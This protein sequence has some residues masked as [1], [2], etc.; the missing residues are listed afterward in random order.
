[1][2]QNES[3]SRWKLNETGGICWEVGSDNHL[4]HED[5]IEMSGMAIS[6]IIRY[7]VNANGELQLSRLLIWPALRTIPNDTHASLTKEFSVELSLQLSICGKSIGVEKPN[8][9]TFDGVLTVYSHT[10]AGIAIVRS[11]FP[12]TDLHAYV[13]M[14][15]L[16]NQSDKMVEIEIE[17][18]N[19]TYHRRGVKGIY[20]LESICNAPATVR[21]H[22]NERTTFALIVHGRGIMED[23]PIIDWQQE[24]A[25]REGLVRRSAR[26]LRLETPDPVLNEGF[27]LAKLRLME[28]IYET[29]SGLMHSPGGGIF[30]AAVWT[31]DQ[32]EYAGPFFAF[33]NDPVGIA[34]SL[35]AYRLFMPFMGP[36]FDPIPT[37]IIAEGTDIWEG[38]GDRGDA[39]MYAYGAS[40]FALIL[41]DRAIAEEL[42]PSI[43]WCLEYNR[44][45]LTSEG[46][47]ASDSDELEN[48]FPSG[49][50]NLSTSSLGYGALRN[51]ASL[52]RSLGKTAETEAFEA[53]AKELAEAIERYFGAEV[54][55]FATYRYY[56]GNDVLRSW[57]CLPLTMG[58]MQRQEGTLEA[59]FDSRLWTPDG[60]ATQAGDTTFWDRSTL[61]GF[62]AAFN[63]GETER[64]MPYLSAYA[65]KRLLGEHVPYPVEAYPE[66][67]Q[68]H[69]S[70]EC[71]LYGRVFTEGMF[72]IKP[73]ALD[74]FEC[75]PR[76]PKAW[77]NMALRDIQLCGRLMDLIVTRE[78]EEGINI[79]V[80]HAEKEVVKFI[81][82]DEKLL[83]R[84]THDQPIIELT[85]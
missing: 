79:R 62:R 71:A 29:K 85:T 78:L 46:I 16:T 64:V 43:C 54:E 22:P 21:L 82:P 52:A 11:M 13:E 65:R 1:M 26:F 30:Y 44:S 10:E 40:L 2:K 32:V 72:G 17:A 41:G 48:R 49:E 38:A 84:F 15:E 77:N 56:E 19:S 27:A 67:N 55:G 20:V 74:S 12:S 24:K 28:S 76:L 68:R 61:Y 31:N 60:L 23:A 53:E 63:A 39:A 57:I 5:H 25:K 36:K 80:I 83:I 14:I 50:A 6:S 58:I 73:V 3:T 42:W 7:G 47:I 8:R 33:L 18:P 70:A 75:V 59:M 45:K 66:G 81:S 34:A 4:P 51:A 9:I 35:N 37:S 69:L